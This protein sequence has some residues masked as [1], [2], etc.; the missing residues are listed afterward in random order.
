VIATRYESFP[1]MAYLES[2]VIVGLS[3]ANL[4][5]DRTLRPDVVIPRKTW[6][7]HRRLAGFLR[8]GDFR[9]SRIPVMERPTT[10]FPNSAAGRRFRS[11]IPSRP[12]SRSERESLEL[13]VRVDASAAQ[14]VREGFAEPPTRALC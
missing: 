6:S 10:R 3:R 5:R 14:R 7:Q 2:H 12:A 8:E 9:A 11:P 1:L 4:A 13:F